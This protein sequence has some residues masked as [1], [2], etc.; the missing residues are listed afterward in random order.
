VAQ[1]HT[2]RSL[3][4]ST[5]IP[6]GFSMSHRHVGLALASLIA[7]SLAACGDEGGTETQ[8]A[9]RS[10]S[11]CADDN[12]CVDGRCIVPECGTGADCV[13]GE[14]CIGGECVFFE[15]DGSG[16]DAGSDVH[17]D[18]G[19][20]DDAGADVGTDTTPDIQFPDVDED[21]DYGPLVWTISP[22]DGAVGVPRDTTIE[23]AFNQPM[24]ALR[25]IP[26]N[27]TVTAEGGEI[28]ERAI[29]YDSDTYILE[30]EP[31]TPEALL[32]P[33]TPYTFRM[34]DL[35]QAASGEEVGEP[36]L[37]DFMTASWDGLDAYADLARAYAPVVYQ[38][39]AE[40]NLDGFTRVDFDGDRDPT[41]NLR[42]AVGAQPAYAYWAVVESQT[43]WFITYIFYY[44]GAH[45]NPRETA[46]HD[47]LTAQVIVQKVADDEL[48]RLRSWVT[49]YRTTVSTWAVSSDFYTAAG[50]NP[51]DVT[52]ELPSARVTEGRHVELFVES[53]THAICLPTADDGGRCRP[54]SG[55]KAPFDDDLQGYIWSVADAPQRIGD[56]EGTSLN[57]ALLSVIDD[58]WLYRTQT[59]GD[60]A[61]FGGEFAYNAP[62]D[63]ETPRPGEGAL[64]P[65]AFNSV[66]AGGTFGEL[67]FVFRAFDDGA[68]EQ[69]VWM[70]DP[71]F[72]ARENFTFTEAFSLEYCFN[73]WLGI[74]RR[75]DLAGCTGA[76][77]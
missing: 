18:A 5:T 49:L 8:D 4:V 64:L 61:L 19:S 71:A 17:D 59:E 48:G 54:A 45:P 46:E 39:V 47:V 16:P 58:L 34:S 40:P 21:I 60:S 66:H 29:S 57:Y 70:V 69:G 68:G 28:A 50:S 74:D 25:M 20:G 30:I 32:E 2:Q 42:S 77:E 51:G 63:G 37:V 9:C 3:F 13:E 75:A 41:D 38:Q 26:S 67:P 23:V 72:R 33:A 1:P 56:V 27:L 24:N 36:V 62:F 22:V 7:L 73:P 53:G 14:S 10:S 6:V 76:A 31:A 55:T 15:S 65:T 12:V 44:P 43:H 11:E 52:G 35:V